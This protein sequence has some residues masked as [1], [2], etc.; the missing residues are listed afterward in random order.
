MAADATHKINLLEL[1][2]CLL[3]CNEMLDM[4]TE[5][6]STGIGQKGP[7]RVVAYHDR[8]LLNSLFY[9][10]SVFTFSF[11]LAQHPVAILFHK[12]GL[13]ILD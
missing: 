1:S 8:I 7:A 4:N 3:C 13:C 12:C 9:N 5:M 2:F 11:S 6:S 10:L